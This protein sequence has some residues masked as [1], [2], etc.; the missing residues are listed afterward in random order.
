[1]RLKIPYTENLLMF[2]PE[3]ENIH[4]V[5]RKK[6]KELKKKFNKL[7]IVKFEEWLKTK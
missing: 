4:L 5:P 2:M 6:K 7:F 3:L 1:M